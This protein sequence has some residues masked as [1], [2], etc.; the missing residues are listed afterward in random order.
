[1]DRSANDLRRG[2]VHER[3]TAF[4]IGLAFAAWFSLSVSAQTTP[5][6]DKAQCIRNLRLIHDAIQAYRLEHK[7][8]PDW[9]SDLSPKYISNPELLVCPLAK[10]RGLT[11]ITATGRKGLSDPRT[12]YIYEFNTVELQEVRGRTN[13]DWKRAQMGLLGSVVPIARCLVHERPVN[14]SF[15]GEVYESDRLEWEYKFTNLI[16]FAELKA[17]RLLSPGTST[18]VIQI[19]SRDPRATPDQVDLSAFFNASLGKPWL[20]REPDQH[21]SALPPGL[22]ELDGVLFD[23]RGVI[24][25]SSRGIRQLGE[26][27]L[28]RVGPIPLNRLCRELHFLIGASVPDAHGTEAGR[29]DIRYGN[30][31]AEEL[32][33][34]MGAH[35]QSTWKGAEHEPA[36]TLAT[37]AWQGNPPHAAR[38]FKL[39]WINPRPGAELHSVEGIAG[40]NKLDFFLV[41]LSVSP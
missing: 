9:L 22:Q 7:D 10:K 38:L 29:F 1:M 4:L 24:Q 5:P 25:L 34:V 18:R 11:S 40:T 39:T 23:V 37:V 2:R 27:F 13:R 35:L 8:L 6:S 3:A 31:Q 26:S 33:L 12:S 32:R 41:A 36:P 19:P 15:G 14:L 30:G 28:E 17:D 16:D 21:L 20:L